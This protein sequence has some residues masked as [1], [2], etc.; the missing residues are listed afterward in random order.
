[1]LSYEVSWMGF[2][3]QVRENTKQNVKWWIDDKKKLSLKYLLVLGTHTSQY[4]FKNI[5]K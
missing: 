4:V 1:M 5:G 2:M 3:K